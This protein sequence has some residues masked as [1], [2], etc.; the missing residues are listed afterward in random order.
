ME[1]GRRRPGSAWGGAPDRHDVMAVFGQKVGDPATEEPGP[2]G[3]QHP[4][5]RSFCLRNVSCS[6]CDSMSDIGTSTG[7]KSMPRIH[8]MPGCAGLSFC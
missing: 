1:P 3:Q 6:R 2:S 7:S 5:M 4:H 8:T